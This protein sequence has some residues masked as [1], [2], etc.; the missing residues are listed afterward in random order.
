[1]IF[2][3]TVGLLI[4]TLISKNQ[5]LEKLSGLLICTFDSYFRK[6][7]QFATLEKSQVL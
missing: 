3:V 6:V 4:C 7:G 2:L 5:G 1:M